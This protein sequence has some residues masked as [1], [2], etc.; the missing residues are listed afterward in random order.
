MTKSPLGNKPNL[1]RQEKQKDA[2]EDA[3]K[4]EGFLHNTDLAEENGAG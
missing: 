2:N 1:V 3:G 4:G